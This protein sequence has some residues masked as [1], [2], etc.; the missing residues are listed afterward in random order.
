MRRVKVY[1]WGRLKPGEP[2]TRIEEGE[3]TFIQYGV[4]YEMEDGGPGIFTTA[5][6]EME[7]GTVKNVNV[8]NIEFIPNPGSD[9][10]IDKGCTCPVLDNNHGR[11]E[12]PWWITE[13]CP[14][15]GKKKETI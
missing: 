7:D 13:G 5:V 8:E 4:G 6:V 3:G 2:Y 9:A 1:R 14:I 11:G 15:H 12:G 10:A